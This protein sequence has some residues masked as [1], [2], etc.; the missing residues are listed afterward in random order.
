MATTFLSQLLAAVTPPP[1]LTPEQYDGWQFRWKVLVFR[2]AQLKTEAYLLLAV[3]L[4]VAWWYIASSVNATKAKTWLKAHL[5]IYDQQFSRP[6]SKAGL[7]S[8]GYSDFFNFST[9]R[10]NIASLHTIF[11]LQPRHDFVQ[12]VFQTGRTLVDLH[13]RPVDDLQLDFKLFPGAL[14]DGF[15]WA[16]VAKDELL[17]VKNGRWDLSFPRAGSENPALPS[18]ILV[19]SEYADIT[20][21]LLKPSGSF[22]LV[23]VLQDPK[24][25]PYFRSLSITDQPRERPT[26]PIPPEEREKHIILSLT[27]PPSSKVADTIPLITAMFQLVD[28]LNKLSLR[29]ET[30]TKLKKSREE[31][32]KVIKEEAEKEAKEE[33]LDAKL[34]A[35]RKA[36]EDRMSKLSAVDQKKALEKERK[37]ALRKAQGKVVRK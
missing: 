37:R 4:Y 15:V 35:K 31:V 5:P 34:A 27:V 22:S 29:P 30:K 25:L 14:A 17:S 36:E 10:R 13:Y 12:W 16:L 11:A 21:N 26:R 8:D 9:G 3:L 1:I 32:D 20:E 2:P 6:Q 19:M 33:A 24:V 28:S 7:V 23:N 18:S